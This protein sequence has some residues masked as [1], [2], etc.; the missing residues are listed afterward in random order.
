MAEDWNL[1]MYLYVRALGHNS[2]FGRTIAIFYFITLY[3]VGNMIFLALFTAL[4]LKS[5]DSGMEE[6]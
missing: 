6:L 5:Q 4:L 3:I 2:D 1:V